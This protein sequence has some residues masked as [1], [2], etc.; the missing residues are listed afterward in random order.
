MVVLRADWC[1]VCKKLEPVIEELKTEYG[2]NFDFVAFNITDEKTTAEAAVTAKSLGISDCFE[3]NMKAT[4][5]V[6]IFEGKKL[7][8]QTRRATDKAEFAAVLDKLMKRS[9]RM[10]STKSD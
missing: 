7:V 2:S 9:G 1:G 6:A 3:L 5:T 4:A 10:A 8:F